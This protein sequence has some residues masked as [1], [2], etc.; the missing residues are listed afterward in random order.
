[1]ELL[2]ERNLVPRLPPQAQAASN[3][4]RTARLYTEEVR[5]LRGRACLHMRLPLSRTPSPAAGTAAHRHRAHAPT[6]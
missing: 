4:F 6:T 5:A 2:F 3:D 1:M